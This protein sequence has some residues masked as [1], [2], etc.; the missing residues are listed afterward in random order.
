MARLTGS[1]PLI[2]VPFA[3]AAS[4]QCQ[5]TCHTDHITLYKT[6]SISHAIDLQLSKGGGAAGAGTAAAANRKGGGE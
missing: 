5:G 4:E 3:A 6:C 1:V 2:A